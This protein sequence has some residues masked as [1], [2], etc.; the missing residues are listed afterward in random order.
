MV[1]T[2]GPLTQEFSSLEDYVASVAHDAGSSRDQLELQADR[3]S[4]DQDTDQTD[5]AQER[6]VVKEPPTTL[7]RMN[8]PRGG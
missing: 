7:H 2:I 1:R 4:V 8:A 6:L 5:I 3:R